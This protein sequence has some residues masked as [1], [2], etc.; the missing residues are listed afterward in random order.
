MNTKNTLKLKVFESGFSKEDT[1]ELLT[2]LEAATTIEDL[3]AFNTLYAEKAL[4]ITYDMSATLASNEKF[5]KK[6]RENEYASEFKEIIEIVEK[7]N[8][9]L[10][11]LIKDG[12]SMSEIRHVISECEDKLMKAFERKTLSIQ[13]EIQKMARQSDPSHEEVKKMEAKL[14]EAISFKGKVKDTLSKIKENTIKA[15][16]A[17]KDSASEGKDKLSEKAEEL[18]K[19]IGELKSNK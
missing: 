11:K 10:E 12:A 6:L 4:E 15:A 1:T 14:K 19:K 5:V 13:M 16:K 8:K 3:D 17:V 9:D 2:A 7:V 18:K